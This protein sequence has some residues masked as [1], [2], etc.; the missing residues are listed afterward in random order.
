[1]SPSPGLSSSFGDFR[2]TG[3]V[4]Y[5]GC[6]EVRR[7]TAPDGTDVALKIARD[8]QGNAARLDR[9]IGTLHALPR[10]DPLAGTWAVQALASGLTPD[11]RPWVALPWFPYSLREWVEVAAPSLPWTLAALGQAVTAVLRFQA[12]GDSPGNPRLHRDLKPDNFLVRASEGRVHVV[13]ADFG[14]ARADHLA[15]AARP[16]LHY[17]PRYGPPEQTLTLAA[18]PDPSIDAHALAVT[19]YWCL[20]GR[21]PDSKGASVAY[22]RAGTRLL[23]LQCATRLKAAE[24]DELETLRRCPLSA[25]V[26]L[27]EMVPLTEAD[28]ARLRTTLADELR[29]LSAPPELAEE[30]AA[31]L[32]RALRRALAPDPERRDGDLR[33]L[34]AAC[35][36][37]T[38]AMERAGIGGAGPLRSSAV[39]ETG[40]VVSPTPNAAATLNSASLD[41]PSLGPSSFAP[42]PLQDPPVERP[43]ASPPLASRP[44]AGITARSRPAPTLPPVPEVVAKD[45]AALWMTAVFLGVAALLV[46]WALWRGVG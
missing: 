2:P 40:S 16:S 13:L 33:Q 19:V 26:E 25:L 31:P 15:N 42:S 30:V 24:V 46:L 32:L 9:E 18:P 8:N 28:E 21:E 45:P 22:T 39:P 6:A 1:M 36:A 41:N 23:D 14:G 43:L 38:G 20:T 17:T 3:E 7:A 29:I 5:G 37:A 4:R 34:I 35:E 11:G 44:P 12:T 10:R 27:D